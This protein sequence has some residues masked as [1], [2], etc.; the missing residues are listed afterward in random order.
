MSK[1]KLVPCPNITKREINDAVMKG[2]RFVL[3]IEIEFI[4]LEQN[5]IH[6]DEKFGYNPVRMGLN[7]WNWRGFKYLHEIVEQQ[8]YEDPDMVGK[9]VKVRNNKD[10]NW[11]FD[12][13]EEYRDENDKPFYCDN[14]KSY[15]YAE[16]LTESD[17]YQGEV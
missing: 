8:W 13:F 1:I 6:W 5:I 10:N 4:H 15:K 17:L 11:K 2:R 16:P 12:I 3:D 9:P 7:A 14:W